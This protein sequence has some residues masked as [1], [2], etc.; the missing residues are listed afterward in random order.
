MKSLIKWFAGFFEDQA[1]S[2]SSKRLVLYICLFELHSIV[3]HV[4]NGYQLADK[5]IL[6]WIV[7]IILFCIGAVTGEF[8]SSVY[9]SKKSEPANQS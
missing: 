9:G 1:G 3:R 4:L 8:L 7:G 6:Y 5:E 2:A